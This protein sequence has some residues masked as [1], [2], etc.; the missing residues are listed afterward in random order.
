MDQSISIT[1]SNQRWWCGCIHDRHGS[2]FRLPTLLTQLAPLRHAAWKR[3]PPHLSSPPC[4]YGPLSFPGSPILIWACAVGYVV[5]F[6]M[7]SIPRHLTLTEKP[8]VTDI[9]KF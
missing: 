9:Q 6:E 3:P 8:N 7:F 2:L 5:S 4:R 1:Q